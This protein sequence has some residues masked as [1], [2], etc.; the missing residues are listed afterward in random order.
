M[1]TFKYHF[2]AYFT[3][4]GII[5]TS[6]KDSFLEIVPSDQLTSESIFA[7]K[8]GAEL[9]M[10]DIY[11][12]L[13]DAEGW[14]GSNNGTGGDGWVKGDLFENWSDNAVCRWT[15][16]MSSVQGVARDYG[17]N[18]YRDALYNHVY[19][20]LP[21]F[22]EPIYT[23]IRKCNLFI[24]QIQNNPTRFPEV[25]MKTRIAEARFLRA[26]FYH[27]I[28]MAYGGVPIV[29]DVLDRLTQGEEI[30]HPR[31]TSEETATFIINELAACAEDL[32]NEV[33][34]GRATKGAAL[35][36]KGWC[37]LFSKKYASA[38][39][40]NLN[41]MQLGV[42]QLF[43]DYNKQ[44]FS[45]NNNNKESIFA[46]QHIAGSKYNDRTAVFGPRDFCRDGSEGSSLPSQNIV[47]AYRMNNG[48]PI[49]DIASGYD[50][51]QPYKNRESRFYQSIIYDGVV[52][53][54]K[55]YSLKAGG[56]S[57]LY[58]PGN[59]KQTGYFRR[60]GII[61]S[62]TA[63]TRPQDASNYVFFRYAE[64][65]LNFAEAKIEM[66]QI[67]QSTIDA[68]DVVRKRGELPML[69]DTYKKDSFSQAELREIVRIERR[70]ELAF[71]NKRYWD[72]I[73][74]RTAMEV[75][76]QPV[77]AM[78]YSNG[79]YVKVISHSMKFN[80]KNYLFPIYQRWIDTNPA[81][82]AQNGGPDNWTNGQNPGY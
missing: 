26:F 9:F 69:K 44:F 68:I 19:P 35:T 75:L 81:I 70:I 40:T 71:E 50:P 57:E 53:A 36:L 73:R 12:N 67:D 31:A 23:Y 76:N 32:P 43:P 56:G 14:K 55:T 48:L 24:S 61:E 39:A 63:A 82:K 46:Y 15:W 51:D 78:A 28:W 37:E 41:V 30:F 72:L 45:E 59:E 62:L 54:G 38:A 11:N 33:G 5:F 42:Y 8:S 17:P 7:D 2:L 60:K 16:G 22:Y 34:I 25:W 27:E 80:E 64:V 74:W 1:N 13:P 65:L 49:T 21:F 4:L 20:T 10:N 29:T 66:G 3:I 6:C 77:Y 58:N 79:K 18:T 47:D 52:F